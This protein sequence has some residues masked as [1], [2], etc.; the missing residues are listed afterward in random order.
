MYPTHGALCAAETDPP[1]PSG[2]DHVPGCIS[3]KTM[4][5]RPSKQRS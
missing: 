5:H 4:M 1:T 2:E 3:G